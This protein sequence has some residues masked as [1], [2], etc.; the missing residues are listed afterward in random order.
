M[1]ADNLMSDSVND[2]GMVSPDAAAKGCGD[3]KSGLECRY[4]LRGFACSWMYY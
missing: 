2:K 3:V 1:N 4:V